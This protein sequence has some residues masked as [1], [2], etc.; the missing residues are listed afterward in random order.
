MKI[1]YTRA[2]LHAALDGTLAATPM[3]VDP[4][5][6]LRV[7]ESCPNVPSEVLSPRNTW[8]DKRAYDETARELVGRFHS[9]FVAFEG[10]VTDDVKASAPRAA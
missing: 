9:N 3:T 6:G 7:P 5:F 2:L 10:Y 4:S 1:Q 8:A